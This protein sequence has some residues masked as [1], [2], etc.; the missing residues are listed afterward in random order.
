MSKSVNICLLAAGKGTRLKLNLSKALLPIRGKKSID[1][2]FDAYQEFFLKSGLKGSIGVVL[3]YQKEKVEDHLNANHKNSSYFTIEQKVVNG[4]GGAVRDYLQAPESD[5]DYTIVTCVDTPLLD[6]TFLVDLMEKL[7]EKQDVVVTSFRTSKPNGYGR[8]I[9]EG[10]NH[11]IVEHKDASAEQLKIS[12]VNAGVYIFKT[13]FL[14]SKIESLTNKNKSGEYYLTDLV[15]MSNSSK[16]LCYEDAQI[17]FGI[18]NI[19]QLSKVESIMNYKKC[20]ELMNDGV[21]IKDPKRTWIEDGVKIAAGTQIFPDVYIHGNCQIAGNVVIESNCIIKNSKI[22]E[23]SNIFAF[24]YLEDSI[25]GKKSNIGP[26]ARL[27][28][29]TIIEKNVKVGNFVEIKK[30][31]LKEGVKASH[32]SY[33]GDAEVGENTNIG[34]GVITVNYDGVN[35]HKTKI[36]KNCFIG[37]DTQLVAPVEIGEECFVACGSTITKDLKNGD[38]GIARSRQINKE[39]MAARFLAPKK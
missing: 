12:E 20:L 3:S 35:K 28:P 8:I 2:L 32:L 36:G 29:G 38:L 11:S 7:D 23:S 14:K 15:A 24:S 5:A 10:K 37:S 9:K 25:V 13:S 16:V 18:N 26:Y 21:I 33:I 6:S 34:C 30:S 4:T 22:E 1:Y 17:F 19:E 31:T 27:R 39:G